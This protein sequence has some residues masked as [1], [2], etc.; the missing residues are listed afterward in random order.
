MIVDLN[1]K[2]TCVISSEVLIIRALLF[3][4][5]TT[6][7]TAM[8]IPRRRSI[9]FTPAATDLHPS[10]KI[11]RVRTVAHVVPETLTTP[12]EQSL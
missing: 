2:P 6:E 7:S 1:Q 12:L 5:V 10:E 9:A 4:F 8:E 11:A 3:K